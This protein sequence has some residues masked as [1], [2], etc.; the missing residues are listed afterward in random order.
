[1]SCLRIEHLSHLH[2]MSASY[3]PVQYDPV[4]IKV[5]SRSLQPSLY[6]HNQTTQSP[7]IKP[8]LLP[9]PP[10]T[11]TN[12]KTNPPALNKNVSIPLLWKLHPVRQLFLLFFP[13]LLLGLFDSRQL[14]RQRDLDHQPPQL[15][16]QP[17]NP[18]YS[19]SHDSRDLGYAYA[20]AGWILAKLLRGW[21]L[22][23]MK[24]RDDL[25]RD[26]M[27]GMTLGGKEAIRR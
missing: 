19:S 3:P 23:L 14:T 26:K 21:K 11:T 2:R 17:K 22:R 6:N 8:S 5:I 9:T 15:A 13:L 27:I 12:T 7:T 4:Y 18:L 10:S 25:V 16:F 1:M 24:V 20:S